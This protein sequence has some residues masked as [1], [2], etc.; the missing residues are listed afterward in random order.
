MINR[1]GSM[2]LI[3]PLVASRMG[4]WARQYAL[5]SEIGIGEDGG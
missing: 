4:H 1:T 2:T 5:F 3:L